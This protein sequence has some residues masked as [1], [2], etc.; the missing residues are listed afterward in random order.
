MADEVGDTTSDES[1]SSESGESESGES[2]SS[3]ESS[4]TADGESSETADTEESADTETTETETTETTG[5]DCTDEEIACDGLDEDCNGVVDDLDL[6]QDGFCDCYKIGII[7]TAGANPAA[8]FADWLEDKGTSAT[9]FGTMPNHVLTEADLADY[10]VLIVDRLTHVYSPQE[11]QLLADWVAAGHGVI[12]M[13]GY[14]NSQIDRDQQNSLVAGLGL[15]YEAPIYIDPTEVWQN[16]P[17]AMGAEAVQI[18]GG[19]RVA[20]NGEVFVRPQG[21]PQNSF[22]TAV[23]FGEGAVIVFSDEWISFDSE[24]QAIPEVRSS[25]PT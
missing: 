21:E 16:H 12:S 18:Y 1:G 9:R 7:G 13:A 3:S 2:S 6:E 5:D 8:N 4:E 11:R 23:E 20:G 15:T 14:T 24:W 17:V 22:G 10:D 25:G 19:W